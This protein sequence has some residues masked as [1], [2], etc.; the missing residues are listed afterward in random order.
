M[1]LTIDTAPDGHHGDALADAQRFSLRI[2]AGF[3]EAEAVWRDLEADAVFSAFQRYDWAACFFSTLGR[4]ATPCLA[5]IAD[6]EGRPQALLPLAIAEE[7]G[8]SV[9]S[10]IGGKHCNFSL[11]LWRPAFAAACDPAMMRAML[12]EIARNAPRRI[13]LYRLVGQPVSWA[14]MDNPLRLIT[15]QPS[16]SSG[17]HLRLGPDPEAILG[18]AMSGPAR[19]KLRKKEKALGAHGEVAFRQAASRA[20]VEAF[21]DIFLAQKAARC[22][23]LGIPNAFAKPC[24]REFILAAATRGLA[25]GQPVIELYALTVAGQPVAIFGGTVSG[26]RFCGM[27]NAM[28]SGPM[29]RES[30]GEILLN[31]LIRHCCE[32][33]LAVFDLGAGKARYKSSLCDGVDALFDQFVPVT[34]RGQAAAAAYGAAMRLKRAIKQSDRLWPL[35]Q[36]LRRARGQAAA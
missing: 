21:T 31:H 2:A 28:T 9:A 25:A 30:P 32:R 6:A 23:E 19:R 7:R 12:A 29:T 15:S 5:I 18:A 14:G 24:A 13:D 33:G 8:L 22:R 20:E 36:S 11:G 10:F 26:G 1:T 35:V 17:Y 16:P 3:A 4:G 27:F 34:W